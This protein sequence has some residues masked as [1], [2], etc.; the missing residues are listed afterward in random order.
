MATQ[1]S[2]QTAEKAVRKA[3]LDALNRERKLEALVNILGAKLARSPE[4]ALEDDVLTQL[5]HVG[6]ARL[7]EAEQTVTSFYGVH[8]LDAQDKDDFH[9]IIPLA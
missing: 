4:C 2:R 3:R 8:Q 6:C 5:F 9:G 7:H 1:H